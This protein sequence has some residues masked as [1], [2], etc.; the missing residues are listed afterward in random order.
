MTKKNVSFL[1]AM[2]LPTVILAWSAYYI[3][4]IKDTTFKDL[5]LIRP[6]FFIMVVLYIINAAS[7]YREVSDSGEKRSP[8]PRKMILFV[9]GVIV[10]PILVPFIG[11]ILCTPIFMFYSLMILDVKNKVR[12]IGLPVI[13]TVALYVIFKIGFSVP[14]PTGFLPF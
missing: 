8:I 1:K 13:F 12:L 5:I 4:S 3:F 6:V 11:F 7:D 14:L 10:Y 9:L 2:I